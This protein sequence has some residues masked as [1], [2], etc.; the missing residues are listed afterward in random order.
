MMTQ[1]LKVFCRRFKTVFT[2]KSYIKQ[3]MFLTGF[4]CLFLQSFANQK[5][6][7]VT[8][9]FTLEFFINTE[10][11]EKKTKTTKTYTWY[12]SGE[13][14]KTEGAIGGIVLDGSFI[15]RYTDNQLA[16]KGIY[17]NGLKH[18]I[19][20][21]WYPNGK[22][23]TSTAWKNGVKK[24]GYK[25]YSELGKPQVLGEYRNDKKQGKWIYL[26]EK[27]TTFFKKGK[28]N[29]EK[30]ER[31]KE[32]E[33][34]KEL[35]KDLSLKERTSV[36]FKKISQKGKQLT[37]KKKSRKKS[38]TKNT[39]KKKNNTRK[40]HSKDTSKSKNEKGKNK[41]SNKKPRDKKKQVR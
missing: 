20:K 32:R 1:N 5:R 26:Q 33:A 17:K 3:L 14:Y 31:L 39:T 37:K 24:G 23:Q 15:K 8:D 35:R 25:A 41:K 2:M 11:K 7:I 22:L 28:R 6:Q 36:F 10:F 34:K 21:T 9:E 16:Q 40:K 19:W 4:F 27:D 29:D 18:G 30:I 13:I 38:R 12:K